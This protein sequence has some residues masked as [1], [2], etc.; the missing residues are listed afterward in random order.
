MIVDVGDG[1]TDCLVPVRFVGAGFAGMIDAGRADD[2]S[3]QIVEREYGYYLDVRRTVCRMGIRLFD[4]R[5]SA[6]PHLAVAG[7]IDVGKRFREEI[8]EISPYE[9]GLVL[10]VAVFAVVAVE[11]HDA[12]VGVDH[13]EVHAFDEVEQL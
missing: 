13:V 12:V 5:F 7:R 2:S 6:G 3:L 1:G 4:N 8:E 10:H 11:R 9:V